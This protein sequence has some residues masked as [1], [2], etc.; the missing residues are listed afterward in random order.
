MKTRR[1][2]QRDEKG[3]WTFDGLPVVIDEG[4]IVPV[5]ARAERNRWSTKEVYVERGN[6][7]I[8]WPDDAPGP[9][10]KPRLQSRLD[11]ANRKIEKVMIGRQRKLTSRARPTA[12]A[13]S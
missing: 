6:G 3:K 11:A 8:E 1:G 12:K 2:L 7:W 13:S 10:I 9:R 4:H 5:T